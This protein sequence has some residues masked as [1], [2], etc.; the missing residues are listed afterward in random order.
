MKSFTAK[1]Q[2]PSGSFVDLSPE[3]AMPLI[4]TLTAGTELVP[5]LVTSLWLNFSS[6]S[7]QTVEVVLSPR[8][9]FP[10]SVTI[11]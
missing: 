1:I 6:T 2:L 11:T 4:R 5:E 7:G 9:G 10:P 3:S 8:E